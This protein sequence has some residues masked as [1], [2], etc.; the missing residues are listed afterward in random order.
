MGLAFSPM[1]QMGF[2][3]VKPFAKG[4]TF[5]KRKD[6]VER[7]GRGSHGQDL[8]V[9]CSGNELRGKVLEG[10]LEALVNELG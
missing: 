7:R 1:S 10:R 5:S 8:L 4:H 3:A 2:P 6:Q 9:F